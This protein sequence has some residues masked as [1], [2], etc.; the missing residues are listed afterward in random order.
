MIL[1]HLD[2]EVNSQLAYLDDYD[3]EA[4][5]QRVLNNVT[6]AFHVHQQQT[7]QFDDEEVP[8]SL[9]QNE[10][11]GKKIELAFRDTTLLT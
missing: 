9:A 2:E 1:G 11:Q 10:P 5:K 3:C 4:T 6:S 8:E 7:Q